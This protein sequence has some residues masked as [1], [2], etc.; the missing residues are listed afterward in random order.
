MTSRSDHEQ[1][2]EGEIPSLVRDGSFFEDDGSETQS[3]EL[4]TGGS[5]ASLPLSS[6]T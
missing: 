5:L 3:S 6:M 1:S 4:S 2:G